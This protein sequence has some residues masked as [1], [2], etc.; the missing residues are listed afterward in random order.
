MAKQ[1]S[2]Y[3]KMS[4]SELSKVT[5][6]R[7]LKKPEGMK[8]ASEWV[9]FLEKQDSLADT[10][11]NAVVKT[12]EPT[13]EVSAFDGMTVAEL[14]DY[15]ERHAID[16]GDATKKADILTALEVAQDESSE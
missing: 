8:N 2:I 6:E 10:K 3:T 4:V 13:A 15:A 11:P 9:A 12:A 16:L 5:R 7:G 1:T 14:K